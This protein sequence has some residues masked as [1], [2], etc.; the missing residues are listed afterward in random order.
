MICIVYRAR[1]PGVNGRPVG[2]A[3]VPSHFWKAISNIV[4]SIQT[5]SLQ[6]RQIQQ[7]NCQYMRWS[8]EAEELWT[9]SCQVSAC[10]DTTHQHCRGKVLRW[11]RRWQSHS[12]AAAA[13]LCTHLCAFAAL[14]SYTVWQP[15]SAVSK[16][17]PILSFWLL[18]L[19]FWL[20]I[21]ESF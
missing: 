8:S 5:G 3:V 2:R 17:R 20:L 19:L 16:F 11:V 4:A 13:L 15:D 9:A 7:C 12:N 18:W 6:K 1:K 21:D 10:G 14:L